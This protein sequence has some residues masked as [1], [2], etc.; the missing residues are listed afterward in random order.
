MDSQN[1]VLARGH[2]ESPPDAPNLQ[3]RIEDDKIRDVMD[4]EEL[5]LI[6]LEKDAPTILGRIVRH[7]GDVVVLEKIKCLGIE[8]R[9]NLRM[10]VRFRSFIYP[11]TGAWRGRRP[12]SSHD[13][14]C[15]GISFFCEAVLDPGE[16]VEIV[17]PITTAPLI[18]RC[19]VLRQRPS[20]REIPLYAAKFVELCDDEERMV[21][22]A[23]FSVQVSTRSAEQ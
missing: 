22:E 18:L 19:E 5:Q 13:L 17:I 11:L 15:G 21:R 16:R 4:H 3:V 23:V 6:G 7:R 14:S 10:P 8:F 9:E 1:T 2:V 12:V 20:H